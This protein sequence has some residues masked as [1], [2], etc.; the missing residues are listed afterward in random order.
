MHRVSISSQFPEMSEASHLHITDITE[1]FVFLEI[2]PG[3]SPSVDDLRQVLDQTSE[4]AITESAALMIHSA[5]KPFVIEVST[6]GLP[7]YR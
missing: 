6:V 2:W 1:F 5:L 4:S 3:I 7:L